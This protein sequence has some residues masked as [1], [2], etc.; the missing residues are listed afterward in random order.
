MGLGLKWLHLHPT[1]FLVLFASTF[2]ASN[3]G[4]N[5]T[6]FVLPTLT[7]PQRVRSSFSG[8]SAACGKVGAL[9]G[10]LAFAPL[11]SS[12]GAG[13]SLILCGAIS[14]ASASVTLAF[15]SPKV[16]SSAMDPASTSYTKSFECDDC[17]CGSQGDLRA[18]LDSGS[19]EQ[20]AAGELGRHGDLL[21]DD[22]TGETSS[23]VP[24]M[25]N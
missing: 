1:L 22:E 12:W 9:I 2:F 21:P 16:G 18:P 24:L 19:S 17:Y 6:T 14:A 3:I 4:P 15:V 11:S 13:P 25:K 20:E 5:S 10:S 8:A 23:T 7:F